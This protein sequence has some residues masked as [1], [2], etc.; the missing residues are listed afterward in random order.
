LTQGTTQQF[1]V[2]QRADEFELPTQLTIGAAYD[3][4]MGESNRLTIAGNFTSNSFTK[5]QITLGLEKAWREILQV[6]AGYTYEQ[7]IWAKGGILESDE[8]MNVNRGLSA[9]VSVEF[10]VSKKEDALRF[11]FDYAFRD[12]YT[13]KGTHSFGVRIIF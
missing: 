10:P 5:D 7:G 9:G 12:T 2:V 8:C 11:A 6:R 13:F 1:T 4:I 3:W